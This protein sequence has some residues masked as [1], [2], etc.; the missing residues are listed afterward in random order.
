[1][2]F[3]AIKAVAATLWVTAIV[4]AGIL[5]GVRSTASWLVMAGIA[6]ALPVLIGRM[7]G[8]SKSMSESIGDVLR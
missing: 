4:A 5:M 6:V 2:Q 3:T 7:R 1:M 8:P